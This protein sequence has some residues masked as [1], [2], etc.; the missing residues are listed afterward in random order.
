M[1]VDWGTDQVIKLRFGTPVL[2]DHFFN[3]AT[4]LSL[5][6]YTTCTV[7]WMASNAKCVLKQD[8]AGG[9]KWKDEWG[10]MK[11]VEINETIFI[12]YSGW[13]VGTGNIT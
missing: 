11:V 4:R 2:L 12:L 1:G 3:T 6:F 10:E 13:I 5:L 9:D 8:Q 7:K